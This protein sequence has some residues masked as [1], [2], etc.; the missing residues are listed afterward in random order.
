MANIIRR[1]SLVVSFELVI[2]QAVKISK[3]QNTTLS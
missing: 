2:P 1:R 3:K